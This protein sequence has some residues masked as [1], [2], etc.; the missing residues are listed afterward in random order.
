[1]LVCQTP[2]V[3]HFKFHLII[4][5]IL[6]DFYVDNVVALKMKRFASSMLF[7]RFQSF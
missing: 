2:S 7:E 3:E 6:I 5:K 4:I 1:M